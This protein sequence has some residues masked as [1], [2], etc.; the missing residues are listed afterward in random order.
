MYVTYDRRGPK[1]L[2]VKGEKISDTFK[3]YKMIRRTDG[4]LIQTLASLKQKE[5]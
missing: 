2:K 4:I 1:K 3:I 5:K